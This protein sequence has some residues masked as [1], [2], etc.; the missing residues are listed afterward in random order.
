MKG[1]PQ[2]L[3]GKEV[4]FQQLEQNDPTVEVA[5]FDLLPLTQSDV[6]R[7]AQIIKKNTH[8]KVLRLMECQL[9]QTDIR[10]IAEA[11]KSNRT[12]TEVVIQK[13]KNDSKETKNFI[14]QIEEIACSNKSNMNRNSY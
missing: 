6:R 4:L 3:E 7:L 5:I 9:E 13:F 14:H 10:P 11:M 12:I 8:L 2:K 1:H